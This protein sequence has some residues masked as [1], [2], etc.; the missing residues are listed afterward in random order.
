MAAIPDPVPPST[1]SV[2]ALKTFTQADL[3]K[4]KVDALADGYRDGYWEGCGAVIDLKRAV[5][6][7]A[8]RLR[9]GILTELAATRELEELVQ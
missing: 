5:K 8:D 9:A 1:P 4:V 3:D 7:I 6:S 2:V